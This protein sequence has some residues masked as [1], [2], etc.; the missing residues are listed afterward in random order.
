MTIPEQGNVFLKMKLLAKTEYLSFIGCVIHNS[1]KY[2]GEKN[3][4]IQ[5]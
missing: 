5:Y 3:E 4:K 1:L 2:G